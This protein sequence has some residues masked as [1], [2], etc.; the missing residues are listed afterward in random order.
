MALPIIDPADFQTFFW[1]LLRVSIIAFMLPFFGARGLPSLWKLGFAMV[2]T[3]AMLPAVPKTTLPASTLGFFIVVISEVI[4][5][6]TMALGVK[7]ILASVQLAGQFL[8]FQMGF[9][10]ASVMDPQTGGQSSVMSQFLYLVT[11][12]IFFSVNG[13]HAFIRAIAYS[14]E[15][16]PPNGF[17]GSPALYTA[18]AKV[19]GEMFVIA[20]KLSAPILIALFLSNLGLGIVA[21]TVPQVNILMVGF[22]INIGLGLILFGIMMNNLSPFLVALIRHMAEILVKAIQLM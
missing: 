4:M 20:L 22:S 9:N 6:F 2:L 19:S 3:I 10:M 11:V 12:L 14:F 5:G 15:L 13:H 8:G 17:S 18:I 7:F 1:A 21:R 16:I